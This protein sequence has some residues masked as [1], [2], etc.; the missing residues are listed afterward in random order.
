MGKSY[1]HQS[2]TTHLW[3]LAGWYG[4]ERKMLTTGTHWAASYAK[5]A[6]RQRG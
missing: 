6:T 5:R 1:R 2:L 3:S 4:G